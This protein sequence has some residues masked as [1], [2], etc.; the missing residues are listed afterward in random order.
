MTPRRAI[1]GGAATGHTR[2]AAPRDA[3]LFADA[4]DL[5]SGNF[6]APVDDWG[7]R[8]IGPAE[9]RPLAATRG[10]NVDRRTSNECTV[11]YRPPLFVVSHLAVSNI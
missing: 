9:I 3:D 5:L 8:G 2:R 4:N 6:R 11:Y 1:N 10:G 7:R